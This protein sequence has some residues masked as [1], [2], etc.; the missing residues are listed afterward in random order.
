MEKHKLYK[1]LTK[2][3]VHVALVNIKIYQFYVETGQCDV[4]ITRYS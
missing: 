3:H 1:C 4:I 2:L